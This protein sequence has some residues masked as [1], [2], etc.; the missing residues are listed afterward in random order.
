[1]Y[2]FRHLGK[3]REHLSFSD[4]REVLVLAVSFDAMS[5]LD[6]AHHLARFSVFGPQVKDVLLRDQEHTRL[7]REAHDF[8]HE[9]RVSFHLWVMR[10]LEI[11]I[12][13]AEDASVFC[14]RCRRTLGVSA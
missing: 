13:A 9:R 10:Y 1:M 11:H 12:N 5:V 6:A 2:R 14:K 8:L 4:K 7:F 3:M